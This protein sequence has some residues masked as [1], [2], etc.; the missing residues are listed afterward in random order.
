MLSEVGLNLKSNFFKEKDLP[1]F[2]ILEKPRTLEGSMEE[3]HPLIE[4]SC[5]EI[6]RLF[7]RQE[8]II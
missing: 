4:Q 7:F 6:I 2:S 3:A 8:S 5:E 1:S